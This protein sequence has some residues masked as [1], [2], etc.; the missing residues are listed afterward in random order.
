MREELNQKKSIPGRESSM[1]WELSSLWRS[2][3]LPCSCGLYFED[4]G[5]YHHLLL[6]ELWWWRRFSL[7]AAAK[8]RLYHRPR[9]HGRGAQHGKQPQAAGGIS[10]QGHRVA[11]PFGGTAGGI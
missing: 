7:K 1:F 10:Y 2:S 9:Q 6:W 5:D 3:R 8:L 11:W 4:A